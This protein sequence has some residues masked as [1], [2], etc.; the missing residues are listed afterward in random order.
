MNSDFK[1][2]NS[3]GRVQV[4]QGDNY[5]MYKLFDDN[6]KSSYQQEAIK[7]IHVDN[8]LANIF[9]SSD[10][11]DYL[12]ESIRYLVYK[13]TCGKHTI[14]K[15]SETELKLIMRAFYLQNGEHKK[16]D[17][18]GE[19]KALNTLVLNYAVPKIIQEINM[20]MQ[21]KQDIDTVPMPLERG[22]LSTSKGTKQLIFKEF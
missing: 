13:K 3:T 15:Q 5:D 14:S 19:V 21:Y 12:Q 20:Y 10:N 18:L 9:F 1:S 7:G 4:L 8:Q 11:I 17:V 16:Y 6:K 22:Q 2:V